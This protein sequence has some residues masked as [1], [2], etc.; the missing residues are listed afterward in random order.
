MEVDAVQD[1]LDIA[2]AMAGQA[3]PMNLEARL[4]QEQIRQMAARKASDASDQCA[5]VFLRVPLLPLWVGRR[6]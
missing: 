2:R 5:H 1:M 4:G 3:N 6:G